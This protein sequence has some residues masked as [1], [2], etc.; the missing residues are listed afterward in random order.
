MTTIPRFRGWANEDSMKIK[1][2]SEQYGR[3]VHLQP[4]SKN[5][6]SDYVKEIIA[7]MELE[8]GVQDNN[9]KVHFYLAIYD[10]K[11]VGL[12]T[13]KEF[14][15]AQKGS[16]KKTV[17]LGVQRLFVRQEF[18]R[19]GIATALLKTLLLM[20]NKGELYDLE[21]DVAFSTPTEQG[22]KLIENITGSKSF[23]V[24]TS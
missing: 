16:E 7:K 3:I 11:V 19:K 9:E 24:Y 14:V 22:R 13:V 4:N 21:N 15:E 20:H 10:M 1:E 18:R 6:N 17:R 8:F 23:F 12:S 2:W 5:T